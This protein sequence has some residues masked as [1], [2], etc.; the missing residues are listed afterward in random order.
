MVLLPSYGDGRLAP[1]EWILDS[2]D[3]IW[4]TDPVG[5]DQDHTIVGTQTVLWD[6][7]GAMTEWELDDA[8]GSLL[9]AEAGLEPEFLISPVMRLTRAAYLAFRMAISTMCAQMT[10]VD[11]DE[12]T[13]LTLAAERYR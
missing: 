6:I 13:R 7:A 1:W 4:K 10:S 11:L 12:H 9:I 8:A 2:N 5:H 3:R